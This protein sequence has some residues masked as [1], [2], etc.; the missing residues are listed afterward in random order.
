M[1]VKPAAAKGKDGKKKELDAYDKL[2]EKLNEKRKAENRSPIGK[3]AVA[4][5][6]T[7]AKRRKL[8]KDAGNKIE[9]QVVTARFLEDYNYVDMDVTGLRE[10][11]SSE[12][13]E[14]GEIDTGSEIESDDNHESQNNNATVEIE[15]NLSA[16]G[17]K[18]V[19]QL[20]SRK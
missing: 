15:Q 5:N 1:I 18:D 10:D 17:S 12:E 9:D 7:E 13:E 19:S 16:K 11:F 20:L 4:K 8:S 6:K 14:E 3:S 2:V